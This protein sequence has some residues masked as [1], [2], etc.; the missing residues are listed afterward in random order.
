ML[1]ARWADL[2]FFF[3]SRRRHTRFKCDWSSD[4][5]SSDLAC[6][7]R[8]HRVQKPHVPSKN[9]T[10]RFELDTGGSGSIVDL[11]TSVVRQGTTVDADTSASHLTKL[12]R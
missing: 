8:A 3:S 6:T 4:V 5:C 9:T 12:V 2:L 7:Q 1:H 10:S 11:E